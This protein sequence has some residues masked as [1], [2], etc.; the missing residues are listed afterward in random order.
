MDKPIIVVGADHG[1]F[2][3][4]N[5]AIEWLEEW[6]YQ[7]KD[8]GASS[9]Q[10]EDDYPQFAFIVAEEVMEMREND[11]PALGVL[12]CRSGGGM[13]IAANKVTGVRAVSLESVEAAQ[14]AKIDNDANVVSLAADW[15]SQKQAKEILKTYI[16]TPFSGEERHQRRIAQI[17]QYEET[18]A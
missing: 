11:R 10:P 12:F 17:T 15:L 1:G 7:V 2:E 8:L 16:Q 4:K 18:T 9:H 14:H 6:G 5:Q 3:L 13:V